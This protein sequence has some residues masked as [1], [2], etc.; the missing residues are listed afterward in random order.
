M[1]TAANKLSFNRAREVGMGILVGFV[2]QGA[3]ASL[4]SAAGPID[5]SGVANLALDWSSVPAVQGF[6]G[7]VTLPEPASPWFYWVA[8]GLCLLILARRKA[9]L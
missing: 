5:N 9:Q 6:P 4:S 3:G 8:A 2:M 1:F 7:S